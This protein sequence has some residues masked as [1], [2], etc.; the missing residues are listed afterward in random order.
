MHELSI[1]LSIVETAEEEAARH[2]DVHVEAIH[3]KLGPLSGVAKEALLFSFDLAC[4]GTSLQGSKLVI[5]ETP[6]IVYCHRCDDR[7]PVNS[8]QWFRCPECGTPV[9][10]V[11][12][13]RELE[14]T[15]LQINDLET[16]ELEMQT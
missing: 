1:A 4:E 8:I 10:D 12:Q 5:E 9:D 7:R 2:G 15:A 13:G 14:I 11:V 3:L 6:V 16:T